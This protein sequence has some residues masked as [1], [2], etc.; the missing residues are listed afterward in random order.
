MKNF[1]PK[2]LEHLASQEEVDPEKEYLKISFP[3]MRMV[4]V[5]RSG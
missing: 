3:N 5:Y 4:M 1:T 2:L